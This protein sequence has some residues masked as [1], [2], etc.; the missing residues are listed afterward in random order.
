MK[1]VL[2]LA[3]VFVLALST[4][5]FASAPQPGKGPAASP[6]LTLEKPSTKLP[7]KLEKPEKPEEEI[8]IIVEL[9]EKPAIE[10]A[11]NK[12]VLYKELSKSQKEQTQQKLKKSQQNVMKTAK[13]KAPSMKVKKEF[14]TVFNGFSANV[15]AKEAKVISEL[16]GVKA[17]YEAT[18]YERPVEKPEMVSS[19]DLV[20]ARQFWEEYGFK[21]EGM[22]VG[23]IDT[24]IDPAHKDMVLTDAS[25]AALKK[26]DI[27]RE[28]SAGQL[29]GG[30]YYT[31]KVPFGYNYMDENDIIRDIAPDAS[32]HG[33]HVAGTVGA[34]GDEENGGI[35][36]IA[37]EAQLLALKVFGND[38]L[39]PSTYGDVYVKAMDDAIKLGADVLNLSLGSTA[40]YVDDK[41]PEQQAVKRAVENGLLVS[42]SAG[43][44]ALYGDGYYYNYADNQDYGLTGSPSVSY[45]SL[46]V[47]S[48]END[49]IRTMSFAYAIDGAEK[50]SGY[51]LAND[52]DPVKLDHQGMEVEDAGFGHPKDFEGKDFNG[53]YALISRGDIAFTEKG[54]NA[55][56]AGAAGVIIYNNAAGT[57]NMASDPAIKIPYMSILQSDGVSMADALKAGKDVTV[58]F[59]GEYVDTPNEKA[60]QMSDFTSWGP[61]PNLDFKPEITAPGGNIFSTLENNQYGIMSGT[62]MAAPHVAG[63]AALL[64]ERID[65]EFGLTGRE[66]SEMTKKLLMN[67]AAPVIFDEEQGD[68]VSPRRQGA[69]L[70]QLANALN[71][72]V[73]VTDKATGEAKVA[74]KEIKD[75]K[76][77][78]ALTAENFSDEEKT[79]NVSY[80]VQADNL[81][82]VGEDLITASNL[83]GSM[84]LTDEAEIDGPE[85]VTVPA[86]GTVTIDA[87]IDLSGIEYLKDYFTNGFFV[88]GFVFLEDPDEEVTGNVPLS[89]PFFGF[90]GSW[91]DAPIFDYF[92]WD[93]RTYWGYTALADE[94]GYFIDGGGNFDQD[95]FGF[96]PDGDG[97]RD[98]VTPVYSLFRNAKKMEVNVL[99]ADG[100]KVRTIRTAA[101]LRKHYINSETNPPYTY[102]MNYAWDGKVN[103]Q[104]AKDGQYFIELKA[105]ID[106]EGAEWQS[107]KFPVKV[108]TAAPEADFDLDNGK[109]IASDFR[110]E[111]TG[112]EAWEVLLNGES[113]TDD[114]ATEEVEMLSPD[115]EEFT[116][117]QEVG[118]DDVLVARVWDYAKNHRDYEL[119]DEPAEKDPPVIYINDPANFSVYD[120]GKVTVNGYVTDESE[121]VSV[122]VNGEKAAEFDGRNFS[123]TLT[124]EDGFQSVKVAAKDEHGNEMSIM[125]RFFVDSSPA[126]LSILTNL[127]KKTEEAEVGVSLRVKDNFDDIR[128]YVNDSEVFANDLSEPYGKKNFDETIEL[129]LPL[130]EGKF[131]YTFKVVDLG[132]H[133][134]VQTV[135]IERK[136]PKGEKP[137]KPG[138]PNPGTPPGKPANPGKPVTPGNPP[139]KPATPGNPVTPGNPPGKPANPGKPVVNPVQPGNPGKGVQG[140]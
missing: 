115:E 29:H 68:Y 113:L 46:G 91:D 116:V 104:L 57:I 86:N 132:G 21:G 82:D 71:T 110:D 84:V 88:D 81:A 87:T 43:N 114:P 95:R 70:M 38:P 121:V 76:I 25:S 52:A 61:T 127:P 60:G 136:L 94:Q 111:G 51:M 17:V 126:E 24:G 90:N 45:D 50:R 16:P 117:D 13:L 105:V 30:K 18:E 98:Q 6:K 96:S 80:A 79:Y 36:G 75:N 56:A 99:D 139:G 27:D 123:H 59:D 92:A 100:K 9:A 102:S 15:K 67:T 35:K 40:G 97:L 54:L 64:F 14:T 124:L 106:Y 119:K 23:V 134:T 8:R 131:D 120:N 26:A 133:E 44:S 78:L 4:T 53:K 135:S 74:L 65:E 69:G 93:A 138:N 31:E 63:G 89:V 103:G 5:A 83:I 37:P 32:M 42:I 19:K 130:V 140:F 39:Y 11:T 129:T 22:V 72:D 122:T 41:S 55:Q 128:I 2:L 3:L 49:M 137:D 101:D 112:V 85:T 12:G 125:R 7:A 48:F 34:N 62:S 58:T 107:I 1:R 108:D 47:A 77:R 33:M 20:Q 118:E 28:L 109:I 73:L 66:R 10:E